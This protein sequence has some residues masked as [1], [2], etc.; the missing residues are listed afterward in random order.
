MYTPASFKV[1]DKEAIFDFIEKNSFAILFTQLNGLPCATHL[2]VLLDR[3]KECLY[4]H[5]AKANPQWQGISHEVLVVFNGPH[6]YISPSW[7]ETNQA[8]PTWNYVAVHITGKFTKIE[9]HNELISI[10]EQTVRVYESGMPQP[11]EI[12]GMN[13]QLLNRLS[14]A[15]VGFKIDILR[16][17]GKWKLSQN[18]SNDRKQR[19]IQELEEKQ[20]D[21]SK[22]I[23]E[24][25]KKMLP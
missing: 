24:W 1:D 2:P 21:N 14:D 23:A 18:H 7:Y 9:V 17:E 19:V 11:W 25:M 15:I 20:D 13:P 3:T 16:I 5:M 6:A 4:G 22:K 8:V 12:G 10:L